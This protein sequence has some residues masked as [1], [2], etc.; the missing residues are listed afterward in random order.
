M[1]WRNGSVTERCSVCDQPLPAG[2]RR[3]TCSDACRQK[4]WRHRHQPDTTPPTAPAGRARKPHTV[5]ECHDCGTR[6]LGVQ[7]CED[8]HRFMRR[9]GYGG[10]SPCCGEPVTFDELLEP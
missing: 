3:T 7:Y 2:R 9:L 6:Q 4:L 1:A 8:C 10:I 5:Y